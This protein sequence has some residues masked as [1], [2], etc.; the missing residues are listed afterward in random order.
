MIF[1]AMKEA[2]AEVT[3]SMALLGAGFSKTWS[4]KGRDVEG[5]GGSTVCSQGRD[6][7]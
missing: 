5:A 2:A 4:D 7:V 3:G 6:C 1:Q